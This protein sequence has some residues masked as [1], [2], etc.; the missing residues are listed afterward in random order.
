MTQEEFIEKL[1]RI[2]AEIH[3]VKMDGG[4]LSGT[5]LYAFLHTIDHSLASAVMHSREFNEEYSEIH[6]KNSRQDQ[7]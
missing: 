4:V 6:I 2:E 5:A 7:V 1:Q 3:D